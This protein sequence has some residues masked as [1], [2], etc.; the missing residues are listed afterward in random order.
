[1]APLSPLGTDAS[2]CAEMLRGATA[3]AAPGFVL[4]HTHVK[5]RVHNTKLRPLGIYYSDC[6]QLTYQLAVGSTVI[7]LCM[8][9]L[10]HSISVVRRRH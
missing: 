4:V 10:G 6:Y 9:S 2:L 7:R 3:L 5:Y 1:M 8:K